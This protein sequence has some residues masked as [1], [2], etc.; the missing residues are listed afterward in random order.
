M[1]NCIVLAEDL[2]VDIEEC[3]LNK[4]K[5]N[6]VK[7]PIEKFYGSNKKYNEI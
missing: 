2:G 5:K 6:E 1:M 7:Y 3:L 4:L